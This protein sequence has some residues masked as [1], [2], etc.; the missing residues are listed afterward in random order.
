[1]KP[2]EAP[3]CHNWFPWTPERP[4]QRFC[5]GACRWRAWL[6]RHQKAGTVPEWRT[7]PK[8]KAR[9]D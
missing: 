8:K 1:M 4:T 5:S 2:C 9:R 3:N 6:D 7:H